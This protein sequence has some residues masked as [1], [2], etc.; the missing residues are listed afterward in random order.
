M[1]KHEFAIM[2]NHTCPSLPKCIFRVVG[3]GKRGLRI[4]LNQVSESQEK[5]LVER[6][7]DISTIYCSGKEL[8]ERIAQDMCKEGKAILNGR[9]QG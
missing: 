2:V 3:K 1:Q 5:P 6:E 9:N 8:W 7:V 4:R